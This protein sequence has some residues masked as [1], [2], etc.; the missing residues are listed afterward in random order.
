M[1]RL[2]GL[3]ARK[4]GLLLL[5]IALI[6]QFTLTFLGANS[7]VG[8]TVFSLLLLLLDLAIIVLFILQYTRRG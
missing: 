1:S 8:M 6:L 4:I 5:A 2:T 3:K 7:L